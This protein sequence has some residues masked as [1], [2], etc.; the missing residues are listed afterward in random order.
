MKFNLLVPFDNFTLETKLA[1]SEVESRIANSIQ[2]RKRFRFS[3]LTD[4]GTKPYEGE[5]F[6]GTF[7]INRVIQ[8]RNSFLPII[9]G[10]IIPM[11]GTT[12]VSI[13]MRP[14]VF[15]LI[16]MSMWLSIV[17]LACLGI[18]CAG[19]I[20]F[21]DVIQHGFSPAIL[22]P[23]AMFAFGYAMTTVGYRVEAQNS[24]E[25]LMRLLDAKEVV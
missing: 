5:V 4:R 12:Q 22:I 7:E 25:F 9:K 19:I 10:S 21:K 8:Y 1:V 11:A 6:G 23:F 13:K 15:V 2:P 3:F 16:F 20:R 17:G 14:A 24:K 18:L